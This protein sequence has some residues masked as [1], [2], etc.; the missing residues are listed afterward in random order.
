MI[1]A[2]CKA[3]R[4]SR[5]KCDMKADGKQSCSR[6]ERL[7]M[8][9]IAEQRKSSAKVLPPSRGS[10]NVRLLPRNGCYEHRNRIDRIHALVSAN[11]NDE[12]LAWL[13]QSDAPYAAGV[14]VTIDGLLATRPE[15]N[16]ARGTVV[17]YDVHSRCIVKIEKTQEEVYVN[18]AN[19]FV[20]RA[21]WNFVYGAWGDLADKHK[22]MLIQLFTESQASDGRALCEYVL[23][24]LVRTTACVTELHSEQCTGSDHT[25]RILRAQR[26]VVRGWTESSSVVHD[27][28]SELRR[29]YAV[30]G[31]QRPLVVVF[32][33]PQCM[34]SA[35]LGDL[36]HTLHLWTTTWGIPI[37]MVWLLVSVRR[38]FLLPPSAP[39][40]PPFPPLPSSLPSLPTT[41]LFA[42]PQGAWERVYE[43]LCAVEMRSKIM[44]TCNI[45]LVAASTDEVATC[46]VMHLLRDHSLPFVHV[47]DMV[48]MKHSLDHVHGSVEAFVNQLKYLMI[49]HSASRDRRAAQVRATI[50][51]AMVELLD[52]AF[53]GNV[54]ISCMF[55]LYCEQQRPDARWDWLERA[56]SHPRNRYTLRT[57]RGRLAAVLAPLP[58]VAP[59]LPADSESGRDRQFVTKRRQALL[60]PQSPG[61]RAE[62]ERRR[63]EEDERWKDDQRWAIMTLPLYL[64]PLVE[65]VDV[66][67]HVPG[68]LDRTFNPPIP[69]WTG[70]NPY[71]SFNETTRMWCI[72]C[73][74]WAQYVAWDIMKEYEVATVGLDEWFQEFRKHP[75]VTRG[76][77]QVLL[78]GSESRTWK[79]TVEELRD[80]LRKRGLDTDGD[81]PALQQRLLE[82]IWAQD[83]Y[84][85]F[86]FAVNELTS[87]DWVSHCTRRG[88]VTKLYF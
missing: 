56:V 48:W 33:D 66:V 83:L 18:H 51:G 4:I 68:D 61:R 74:A 76:T 17:R 54:K 85:R 60:A 13:H 69:S 53:V 72:P 80:A 50:L 87:C 52:T 2:A 45:P 29:W 27:W 25:Q 22:L 63:A 32:T 47:E 58:F 46:I 36:I 71:M 57:L 1:N 84:A 82:A 20:S 39:L 43:G 88:T 64:Q 70:R 9:C 67:A 21:W 10:W 14:C 8:Q 6:C 75:D 40:F 26:S 23:E 41:T 30:E 81:K 65:G 16:G 79:M 86:R 49:R 78:P 31:K 35:V 55:W 15:L 44:L 59:P 11:T 3:C 77:H 37:R 7:G 28:T 42:L 19:L 12:R 5:T 24:R 62:E 73:D 34:D 38:P